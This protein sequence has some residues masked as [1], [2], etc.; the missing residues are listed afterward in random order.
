MLNT[1]IAHFIVL[2][3]KTIKSLNLKA[4]DITLYAKNRLNEE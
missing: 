4:E 1:F 2:N 3:F